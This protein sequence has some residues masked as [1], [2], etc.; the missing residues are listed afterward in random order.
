M[1]WKFTWLDLSVEAI[2]GSAT[3][4]SMIYGKHTFL[5]A[6]NSLVYYPFDAL[7]SARGLRSELLYSHHVASLLRKLNRMHC[8]PVLRILRDGAPIWLRQA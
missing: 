7:I 8:T 3:S 6:F 2:G 1:E 4:S 5:F